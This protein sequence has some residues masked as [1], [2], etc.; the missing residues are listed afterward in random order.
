[1]RRAVHRASKSL[2]QSRSIHIVN[3]TNSVVIASAVRTPIGSFNG[4]LASF[5]APQL[6]ALAVRAALERAG[7]SKSEVQE[8]ILGN[9]LSADLGQAPARQAVI[10]AGLPSSVVC[11]TINKMCASGTKSIMLGAQSIMLGMNNCVIAG[12]FE[13][14][15][16]APYYVSKAR[17]GYK[18]GDGTL[19]DSVLRDGLV[20][21][22]NGKHM[23]WCAEQTAAK[24]GITREEQDK[25][26]LESYRRAAEATEKGYFKNELISVAIPGKGETKYL[27]EDEEIKNLKADKVAS[28][29]PAFLKENGTV[30][31]ANASKLSDGAAALV[32][33]SEEKAKRAGLKPLARIRGFADAER[34]PVEF[35]IAPSDAIPRA[36]KASGLEK[37]DIGLYELNEAF[38]VVAL[39]NMRLLDL[40]PNTVSIFGGAVALGHPI[41]CSGARIVA[42]LISALK[43][44][45]ETFGVAAICN[46]GGGASALVIENLQ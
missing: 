1:M 27:N 8:V 35:T 23:G 7:V 25:Y 18:M 5:R 22:F 37:K 41:G 17:F 34:D 44:R 13:S 45:D 4:S 14:M 43:N 33:L 21:A 31:A 12:G 11:T 2:T 40:D 6:G 19:V 46:G 30:T 39:A 16:N 3:N 38:S 42:T 26:A 15:T 9:V 20:D 32:L 28:L 10:E 36:L 29:R 24:Y